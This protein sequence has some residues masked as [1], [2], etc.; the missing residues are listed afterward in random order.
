MPGS[1][2]IVGHPELN[3]V[4][5]MRGTHI[6]CAARH[7]QGWVSIQK[8]LLIGPKLKIKRLRFISAVWKIWGVEICH[9]VWFWLILNQGFFWTC[10]GDIHVPSEFCLIKPQINW[11]WEIFKSKAVS[12]TRLGTEHDRAFTFLYSRLPFTCI[13]ENMPLLWRM[14]SSKFSVLSAW[15]IKFQFFLIVQFHGV[16]AIVAALPLMT[17]GIQE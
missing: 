2:P 10:G 11:L 15:K 16:C 5:S 17:S 3:P 6:H 1:V 13:T 4:S 8:Y 9:L 14:T 12:L 7:W